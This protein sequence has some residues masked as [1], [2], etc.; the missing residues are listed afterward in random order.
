MQR[1]LSTY[2]YVNQPLTHALL[3]EIKGAG[4]SGIEIFC[5][6]FHFNYAS[7]QSVR[8]LAASLNELGLQLQSLHAP[9]E[10]DSSLGRGSGL[11]VSISEPERIRRQEAV[12]EVKRALDVAEIIPFRY[13]V[14]HLGSSRQASDSRNLDAAF[15]SLEHLSAF[16][17]QRGVT[18][19][20]ENTPSEIG[21]PA[22]LVQFVKE[23]HLRDLRF[24]FDVCHA[25]LDGGIDADFGLMRELVVTSHLHDNHGEKD[26]H[27]LPY[28]G[29]IDW[30]A[31]FAALAALSTAPEMPALVLELKDQS[32]GAPALDQIRAVF[33]KLEKH[34]DK[35]GA[36]PART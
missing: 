36:R 16:A 29:S 15:G 1:V 7:P 9:T 17:K 14:Q 22:S 18:I 20:L 21:A 5:S 23:T 6:S 4:I 34:L 24:C 13:L 2:R 31:V 30:D 33:D 25:H 19:A 12:D 32:A 3:A 27:L 11:P 35:K 8:E 28:E 26:E 10:R